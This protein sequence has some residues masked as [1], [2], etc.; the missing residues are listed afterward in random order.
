L[1]VLT[2][3][4]IS[5][6]ALNDAS[7]GTLSINTN[8]VVS[9]VDGSSVTAYVTQVSMSLFTAPTAGT[10]TIFI[11]MLNRTSTILVFAPAASYQIPTG[12]ISA[13]TDVQ[14]YSIPRNQLPVVA[15]QCVGVGIGTGG[16]SLSQVP[17]QL[18]PI[19]QLSYF[20]V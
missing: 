5:N 15:G 10:A 2:Y 17:I 18:M 13:T 14:T 9:G 16:G 11:F 19:E 3:G 7:N 6:N 1:F 4:T 20:E 8:D 12:L